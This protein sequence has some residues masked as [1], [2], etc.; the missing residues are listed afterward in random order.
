[1]QYYDRVGEH[2]KA[3]KLAQDII[4]FKPKS[5]DS[6]LELRDIAFMHYRR[7]NNFE[8]MYH[9]LDDIWAINEKM[10]DGEKKCSHKLSSCMYS[11]TTR[12]VGC[13]TVRLSSIIIMIT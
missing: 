3:E 11:S 9:M 6:Y 5:F 4:D 2:D 13:N 8:R 12:D 10:Q 1:M 7:T